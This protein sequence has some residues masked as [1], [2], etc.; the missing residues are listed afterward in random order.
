MIAL[1]QFNMLD[2]IDTPCNDRCRVFNM[3]SLFQG[4]ILTLRNIIFGGCWL[5][6]NVVGGTF[7]ITSLLPF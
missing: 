2:N 7:D 5:K 1:L 6:H 3:L 4:A